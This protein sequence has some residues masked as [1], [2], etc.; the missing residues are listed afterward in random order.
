MQT[1]RERPLTTFRVADEVPQSSLRQE[2]PQAVPASPAHSLEGGL[3]GALLH[4]FGAP[5]VQFALWNGDRVYSGAGEPVAT[6][7]IPDKS[8]LMRLCRDPD[9]QFGE[10]YSVGKIQVE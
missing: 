5:P 8:T 6:L 1:S 7:H 3:L 2:S 4:A 10:L 9:V